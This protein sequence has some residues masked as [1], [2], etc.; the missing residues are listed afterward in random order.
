MPKAVI[1]QETAAWLGV[2]LDV[3]QILAAAGP[4]AAD[5]LLAIT[6]ENRAH[7]LLSVSLDRWVLTDAGFLLA[8]GIAADLMAALDP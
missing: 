3:Q 2:G 6:S 1:H 4:A 5:R 8:D 7:A